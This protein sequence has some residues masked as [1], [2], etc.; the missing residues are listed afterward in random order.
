RAPGNQQASL[1]R[2]FGT[3]YGATGPQLLG[4]RTIV[5]HTG[6]LNAFGLTNEDAQALRAWYQYSA[7]PRNLLFTG[8]G[9]ANGLAA[10][11]S[12]EDQALDL[13]ERELG[14][15]F[16]C[17]SLRDQG[18][19]DGSMP[20]S[21]DCIPVAGVGGGHFAATG[22]ALPG[23]AC[24]TLRSFDVLDVSPNA[25]G[26]ARGNLTYEAPLKGSVSYASVSHM[27]PAGHRSVVDGFSTAYLLSGACAPPST[28]ADRLAEV[29]AWFGE[30]G[31]GGC[32]DTGAS[33]GVD[34]DR[35]PGPRGPVLGL[36]LVDGAFLRGPARFHLTAPSGREVRLEIYDVAGR[37]VAEVYRGRVP[38]SGVDITWNTEGIAASGVYFARLAGAEAIT[39]R[40]VVIR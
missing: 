6:N 13:L 17:Q 10:G 11:Y 36:R 4:Y 5:W 25:S 1:G 28:A 38:E 32:F 7:N 8:D 18:C 2:P 26:D 40:F 37:R 14:T 35:V 16:V 29:F 33:L 9:L 19:P 27:Q 24:P 39:R 23:N 15:S 3:E 20:D 22:A 30:T 12:G 31:T 34:D 21:T